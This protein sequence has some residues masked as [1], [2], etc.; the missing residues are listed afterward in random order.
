MSALLRGPPLLLGSP[1]GL[2]LLEAVTQFAILPD[3]ASVGSLVFIV[4]TPE[5]AWR[6]HMP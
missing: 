5:A 6:I 2:S 1:S 3:D 4:V